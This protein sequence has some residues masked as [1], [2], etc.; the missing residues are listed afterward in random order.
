MEEAAQ[1][2]RAHGWAWR[3]KRM[4]KKVD[5]KK[6]EEERGAIDKKQIEKGKR[7]GEKDGKEGEKERQ[8]AI[9]KGQRWRGPPQRGMI[10]GQLGGEG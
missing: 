2:S 7:G 1:R 5:N 10:Y 8:V 6:G 4:K 3:R 9:E